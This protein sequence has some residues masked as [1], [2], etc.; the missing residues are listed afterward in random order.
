MLCVQSQELFLETNGA[1]FTILGK[2]RIVSHIKFHNNA[3][4]VTISFQTIWCL[5]PERQKI[6]NEGYQWYRADIKM[7]NRL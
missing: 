4:L 3:N 2:R 7:L 5:Q 6:H 1:Y